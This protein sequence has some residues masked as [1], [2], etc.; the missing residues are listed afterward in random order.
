MISEDVLTTVADRFRVVVPSGTKMTGRD[1]IMAI[2]WL[3]FPS[4][5][6]LRLVPHEHTVEL[7][8]G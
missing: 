8:E 5:A 2:Q 7:R 6:S 3:A 1:T 4:G